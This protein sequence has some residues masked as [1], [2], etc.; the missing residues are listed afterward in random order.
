MPK[1]LLIFTLLIPT[2]FSSVTFAGEANEVL[3]DAKVYKIDSLNTAIGLKEL[4][5][6]ATLE[7][8]PR[9]LAEYGKQAG[10]QFN[11]QSEK[12]V[13]SSILEV[14]VLSDK[15]SKT[16]NIDINLLNGDKKNISS[17]NNHPI[18]KP[19]IASTIIEDASRVIQIDVSEPQ[20]PKANYLLQVSS[21]LGC[22][23]LTIELQAE[24][25][26]HY[27]EFTNSAFA[28]VTLPQGT[29]SFGNVMCKTGQTQQPFDVLKDKLAPIS[30]AAG[31]TYFGGRLIFKEAQPVDGSGNV[32]ESCTRFISV[33][34]GEKQD[35]LCDG[36]GLSS[37]SQPARRVEVFMPDV[38]D[39]DIN[40]VRQALSASE[41]TLKYLPMKIKE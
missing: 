3:I 37:T 13:D 28:S 40:V 7:H 23:V 11:Y 1:L 21:D 29:F 26:S 20:T 18:G 34:R 9:L 12:G 15:D 5:A 24:K 14:L 10:I 16:Y 36:A 4:L 19:F 38:T 6:G 39:A 22:E 17:I 31:Q 25:Q 33:A 30:V 35:N 41:E 2:A 27:L 32:L 8:N